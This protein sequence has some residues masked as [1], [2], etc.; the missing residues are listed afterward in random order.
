[1]IDL[2]THSN[3]SD[4]ILSP[5]ELVKLASRSR[6]TYLALTDHDEVSGIAEA[7]K[8]AKANDLTLIPGIE[9]SAE[10]NGGEVHILG[11]GIDPEYPALAEFVSDMRKNRYNRNIAILE[12]LNRDGLI[13]DNPTSIL[14]ERGITGR[15][16][17]AAY[18]IEKGI[19]A[20]IGEAFEKYLAYNR[21]YY[22]KRNLVAPQKAFKIIREAGGLSFIAHP[23]SILIDFPQ[24]DEELE[25]LFK[26]WKDLG[27][28]GIETFHPN[29]RPSVSR[30]F[31][32]MAVKLYL[33]CSGGSDYHGF[34]AQNRNLGKWHKNKRIPI[35]IMQ[36]LLPKIHL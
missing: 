17:I 16:H 23:S 34:T 27:L 20:N 6:I 36:R 29:F 1:M 13:D 21:K 8:E 4:G 5:K 15:P 10:L 25:D 35:G 9:I 26:K 14:S 30:K 28:D 31:R 7:K 33:L 18:L 2:H 32:A 3:I 24:T 19:A 22:V 11:L 12:R